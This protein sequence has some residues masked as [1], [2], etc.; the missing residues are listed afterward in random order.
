MTNSSSMVKKT[1][2]LIIGTQQQLSKVN[3]SSITVG[4]SDVQSNLSNT[5][6]EGTEQ[7]VRIREVTAI[8][9]LLRLH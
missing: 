8:T 2:F 7:S 4:N 9:S 1:E 6:T 3:I 5:D